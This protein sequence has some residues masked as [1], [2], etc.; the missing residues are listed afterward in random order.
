MAYQSE[1]QIDI[2][3]HYPPE[4]LELLCDAVPVLV[5]SK[6]A[7]IDFFVGAGV[8]HKHL[9]DWKLKL[10]QDRDSVKKP[11]M[12]RSVLCRLNEDGE[13]ALAV[14]REVLKRV[15][16]FEDFSTCW[17]NDRYK[18]QGLVAQIQK[19]I[20][21]KDSF[22]RMNLERE[23]ER[24]EHQA[25]YAAKVAAKQAKATERAE[26]KDAL[27]KLFAETNPHKRGKALEGA[28]NSLFK[29][30]GILVRED[31]TYKGADGEGV[32]EQVDGSV[33]I[34]SHIYLVEMKW[35]DKPI[36]RAEVSPHLV[37][38]FSRA[39]ARG[40]FISNSK[41]TGPAVETVR[42]AINQKTCVLCELEEIVLALEDDI[43]LGDL[44]RQ[45]VEAAIHDKQPL[46]RFQRKADA[47]E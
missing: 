31:F 19:L 25:Q 8:P 32:L 22:T 34:N 42:E 12:A 36:G 18:A 29:N 38:L 28:L 1:I 21:V 33:E 26:L 13:A 9:S 27:Y 7:V 11:V 14:R 3:Y 10:R 37:R 17:E 47:P 24:R 4:L 23:R 15:S 20:N 44:F 16:Q 43:D 45:K 40:I 30:S 5:R 35:W 6:Q 39:D 46:H 41:F 2:T